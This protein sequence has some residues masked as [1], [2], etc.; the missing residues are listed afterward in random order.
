MTLE[1]YAFKIK[2]HP[3]KFAEYKRRHDKIW[4]E[5]VETHP[6]NEPVATPLLTLFHR[7]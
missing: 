5:I 7:D 4:P 2:L 6:N 3:G 1:I